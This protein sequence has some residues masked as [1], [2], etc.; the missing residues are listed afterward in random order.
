MLKII[1]S[2]HLELR[3]KVRNISRLI[4][5]QIFK[6]SKEHYL[7]LETE[8]N[9]AVKK[10]N[11]KGKLREMA[12]IYEK[13]GNKVILITVHPLKVLQKSNRI[14]TKRWQKI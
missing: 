13:T 12:V 1:Y 4:P 7:D 11:Y 6:T 3:L 2:S 14:K 10:I 9:V 8:K 5:K